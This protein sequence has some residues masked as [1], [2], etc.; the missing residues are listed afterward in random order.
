MVTRTAAKRENEAGAGRK[1]EAPPCRHHWMIDAP[2]ARTSHGECLL[3]QA[4]REFPN[5]LSDCL[6]DNDEEKFEEWLAR[7]GRRKPKKG[8]EP[9]APFQV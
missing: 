3:C 6:I 9:G 4:R 5:Y 7:Q 2:E 1:V 8:G